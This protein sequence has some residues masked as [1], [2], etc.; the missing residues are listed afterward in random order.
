MNCIMCGP[1]HMELRHAGCMLKHASLLMS[2]DL[3]GQSCKRDL[4]SMLK[5][6]YRKRNWQRRH[7]SMVLMS[8]L[9]CIDG[10]DP[11]LWCLRE[12]AVARCELQM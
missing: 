8:A 9:L 11:F 5:F 4:S 10:N 1:S 7:C 2:E 12:E 6:T 3:I